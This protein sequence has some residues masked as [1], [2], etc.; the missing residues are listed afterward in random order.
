LEFG[1]DEVY[2]WTY[3]QHLAWNYFDHP[4]MVALLIRFSTINLFFQSEFFIR[5]GSILCAALNTW[6]IFLTGE[7][8]KDERTGWYAALLFTSSFYCSIIAGTFI[9]PDS[10][11]LLFWILSIYMMTKIVSAKDDSFLNRDLLML[12]ICIGLCIMSKIHGIFLWFGFGL[13]ILF[14]KRELL[15]SPFL[16]LSAFVTV[17]IISPI[18]WW[19]FQNHFITYSFHGS[20]VGFFGKKLDTDSLLQQIFGSLFYNNPVSVIIY[21]IALVS[22]ARKGIAI[23]TEYIRLYLL[24]G[25][26]LIIVLLVMSMFNETLPHWSGPAYITIMLLAAGWLSSKNISSVK[27]PRSILIALGLFLFVVIVALPAIKWV[28]VQLGSQEERIRGKGDVTLD[29]SGWDKFSS[30]FDSLYRND[31][32]TGKMKKDAFILSD[33]WFPAA[34]LDYYLATPMHI[35][36][37]A[38]GK[39]VDIHH[40]AWL[41]KERPA[42][43]SGSDAYFIYPSNYYGPPREELRQLFRQVE[44][45]VIIV[46]YRSRIHV[47]NFVIYRMH[48]YLGG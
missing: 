48:D 2:Y 13:Y 11:Q 41:N 34:H 35:P 36:F 32:A 46:Q 5:L 9:L 20:R 25:F 23:R 44:D 42:F 24:L 15:K 30:Q 6:I 10:P 31:A 47:R 19:N 3:A 28:P 17:L 14:Y 1:N 38:A 21:V 22:I 26:P 43:T 39:L 27:T 12:G 29:M 16:Y 4:P 18:F 7:K 8:V 45:S 37:L 40:Y 33:Y